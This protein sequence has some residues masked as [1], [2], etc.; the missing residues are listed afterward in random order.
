[1]K[2]ILIWSVFLLTV[3][4]F[5]SCVDKIVVADVGKPTGKIIIES[6]PPGAEIYLL[7]T[8]TDKVTPDSIDQLDSGEYEITLKKA[9]YRD[10]TLNI[11]VYD[12]LTTFR[13][14]ILQSI[15]EA[16]NI[17][18]ESEP[19]GAEIFLDSLK[20][21]SF[22]PDTLKNIIVGDHKIT[23][24]KVNYRDTTITL[25]VKSKETTSKLVVMK[26]LVKTGNIYLETN[27]AGAQIFLDSTN[28][29]KIT[30]DTL[31]NILTGLHTI[32]LKKSNYLDTT[33]IVNVPENNTI[34]KI[35]GLRAAVTKGNV[36]IES[37]PSGAQ[38]FLDNLN[39]NKITPDILKDLVTGVHSITLKKDSYVDT[40]FKVPIINDTTISK[41]VILTPKVTKGNIYIS[42]NPGSAQIFLDSINTGKVTPDTLKNIAEGVHKITLKKN[43]YYDTTLIVTVQRNQTVSESVA[44][45]PLIIRGN[46]FLESEPN[47][48][49]IYIDGKNTNKVT[50]DTLLNYPAG[51]H[52]ITLKK[53]DF[54]DTTFQINVIAYLTVSKKIT[55]I[56]ING[57][58][59]IQSNPSGA[60]IYLS[61]KSTGKTTPDTLKN[62]AEGTYKI[63][64][65]YPDYNDTTFYSNVFQNTTTNENITLTKMIE[66][67]DLYIQSD[68]SGADIYV[69]NN[70]T[71]KSTPDT[72]KH[73]VV[74]SHNVTLKLNGYFDA[75]VTL[76]IEK[77]TVANENITLSEILPVQTDTL[78]YSYIFLS[79]QT[80]FT[81]SFNQDITLDEVDIIEPGSTIKNPFEFNGVAV[82]KGSTRSIYYQKYLTGEWQLIF[83]GKKADSGISFTLNK[84]ITIP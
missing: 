7:G 26:S 83:Y 38:I 78:Y 52:S 74:G 27:P 41:S 43:N 45:T 63:T 8:K 32:I 68:P 1:M 44:L 15:F 31:K 3:S 36:Y 4:L 23:L 65:K 13:M 50:P 48:A 9:N 73:L 69:D 49:Q 17:F 18:L 28:T 12:S 81:F 84:T 71:G 67:G 62:L 60:D 57:N 24:K 56:S 70:N 47:G 21:N 64:L 10:T 34:S 59:F 6:N 54:R 51:N 20:T 35:I 42:S 22:T 61:D 14:V 79:G 75:D 25:T 46:I 55:L 37:N 11:T 77:G 39:T 66:Y 53:T 16:G 58:I 33:L 72:I 2:N 5:Q 40:T 30:P 76:N 82:S 19:V 80:K 29:G